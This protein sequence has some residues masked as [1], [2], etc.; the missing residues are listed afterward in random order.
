MTANSE[1]FK[2]LREPFAP[3]DIEWRIGQAGEGKQGIW[4]K[5]LA[6]ITNRA[7]MD[8]LD[9]VLGPENWRNEFQ[10]VQGG[11]MCGL[12][13]RIGGEWITKW[14]G[15][16][17]SDIEAFKG[18]ISGAM[19]RAAVQFGIGRYLYD[20]GDSWAVVSDSGAHYANCKIKKDGAEK[21]VN[22]KWDHPKLPA[23]ALPSG[24]G[25]SPAQTVAKIEKETGGKVKPAAKA[26]DPVDAYPELKGAKL[27]KSQKDTYIADKNLV[28]AA[29]DAQQLELARVS[30][31]AD[32]EA[33]LLTDDLAEMLRATFSNKRRSLEA[34][35]E[36]N[37]YFDKQL[38][39]ELQTAE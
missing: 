39:R 4:A 19:K 1:L 12:S 8:R 25:E 10:F 5:V 2:K 13:I 36:Q 3:A 20:L 24:T 29:K 22:F 37:E 26:L 34:M 35:A 14:D 17:P 11:T 32:V 21:W 33:G 18:V 9:D 23:W 7:I 30:V 16:D 15:S 31:K 6:Y 27:T 28:M 38:N